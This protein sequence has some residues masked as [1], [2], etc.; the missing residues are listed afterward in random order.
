MPTPIFLPKGNIET[1]D[2]ISMEKDLSMTATL[3]QDVV[4]MQ[5][6]TDKITS[7]FHIN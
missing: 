1:H 5:K 4:E 2:K 7:D 6:D 3:S